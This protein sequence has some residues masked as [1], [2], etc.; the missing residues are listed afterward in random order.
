MAY[1]LATQLAAIRRTS[2]P[3]V[4][5]CTVDAPHTVATVT[6]LFP[7]ELPIAQWDVVRGITPITQAGADIVTALNSKGDATNPVAM[8]KNAPQMPQKSVL[9]AHNLHLFMNQP[10]VV[11]AL[12][13]L[14]DVLKSSGATLILLAPALTLPAEIRQ[15]I[16][17]LEEPLPDMK[18]L[19]KILSHE[20]K[21]FQKGTGIELDIPEEPWLRAVDA[22]RGLGPFAAEAEVAMALS[23]DGLDVQRLWQ[24]KQQ[25]IAQTPGLSVYKGTE[26]FANVGGLDTLKTFMRQVLRGRKK[27]R[28]LA[29]ID[30]IEKCLA[31]MHG[32]NT[33]VSQ[34]FL[35]ALLTYMQETDTQ[36]LML[37]GP[38]GTGKSFIAKTAGNEAGIPTVSIDLGAMKDSHVGASERNMRSAFKVL[39]AISDGA[40]LLVATSNNIAILPP[41]LRRRFRLG[42]WVVDLPT[43]DEQRE[44]WRVQLAKYPDIEDHVPPVRCQQWTGADIAQCAELAWSL[45][46]TLDE[47]A[48]YIVP[49]AISAKEE[50]E[51]LRSE[52]AGRYLSASYPG[53]YRQPQHSTTNSTRQYSL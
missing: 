26:T 17:V 51:R 34:D 19:E 23:Q 16:I 49:V 52:A 53:L 18:A 35:G 15:D 40:I 33:G 38:S 50:I 27:P 4:A 14:R 39:N 10:G 24:R 47:A 31:G 43:E 3:L 29:W 36:G 41:E 44:I 1:A 2:A 21:N 28:A 22:L 6:A 46:I 5:M 37:L 11:Q 13:N 7:P 12:A 30:E 42:T 9:F 8:L 48:Q 25:V 20:T 32:D 45:N